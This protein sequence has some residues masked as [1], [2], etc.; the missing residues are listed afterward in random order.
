MA[1]SLS[2]P[3]TDAG[4]VPVRLGDGAEPP[5]DRLTTEPTTPAGG[6][7]VSVVM[8]VHDPG[9]SLVTS[10]RSV[11]SQSWADLEVLLCDDASSTGDDVLEHCA[12]L[13]PRV[14]LLRAPRNG[15]TYAA[16]NLGLAHA[17]GRYLTFQDDDDFAHPQRLEWEVGALRAGSGVAVLAHTLRST[18]PST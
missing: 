12:G 16:R 13:D 4:L 10:V 11:L 17:R 14:R 18:R 9:P 1:R 3:F 5:F 8:P 15:G 7:L 2:R 6:E